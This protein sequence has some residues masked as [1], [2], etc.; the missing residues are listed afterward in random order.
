MT[1][2]EQTRRD[3]LVRT[4]C[5]ALGA[6]AASASLKRFGL[7]TAKALESAVSA[8]DPN[9]KAL[10]CIFLSGGNDSNNMIVPMAGSLLTAYNTARPATSGLQLAQAS[11]HPIT[12]PGLGQFGLHANLGTTAANQPDPTKVLHT[13]WG[14]QRLAVVCNV[15][16]LVVPLANKTA[17]NSSANKKPYQL[18]SHS[19]QVAQWQTSV[20]DHV[21]Q[22]GW[23][24]RTADKT[25]SFNLGS[26]F[27]LVT[28]IAGTA[29]FAQGIQTRPLG[30]QPAPTALNNILVLNGFASGQTGFN[31]TSSPPRKL[32]MDFLRTIDRTALLIASASDATE[33]AVDIGS[34]LSTDPTITTVFP[35]S[36]LANQLLQVAK[37]IKSHQG[38]GVQ[39][40]IFFCQQGGYDTHQ[41]QINNQGSLF[42]DLSEAMKAFYDATVELQLE[43]QVTT[44]T[45][46]DF[47]RTLEPSG[48]GGDVGTDHGWGNHQFVMG[49][50]VLG[51]NFYGVPGPSGNVFPTLTLNGPDDTD[52]RGR[53]IPSAAVDQYAATL[54]TWFG[55]APADL[56]YVFPNIGHFPT[57][58]LGFM[59]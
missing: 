5:A 33:Q 36:G 11:L 10:V 49:G 23:G 28:S 12:V 43:T 38:L 8:S 54:A 26:G 52:D 47:G 6:A 31:G 34:A 14:Q 19:D 57:S 41:D 20:S 45:L 21:S 40:Q 1:Q 7:L 27:P 13:L 48:S 58:D 35:N 55:L 24:G 4:S 42:Q 17:Y 25:V 44:F 56:L 37:V 50:S 59:A 22:T 3:F 32:S 51:G 16:P 18:F 53:W 30:I 29:A 15:G 46:S 2:K 39:R 9:Y